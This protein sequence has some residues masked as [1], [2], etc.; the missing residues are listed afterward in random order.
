MKTKEPLNQSVNFIG[1]ARK[2]LF[3][4]ERPKEIPGEGLSAAAAPQRHIRVKVTMNIDGDLLEAFKAQAKDLGRSYQLLINEV[5]REHVEGTKPER[6][7]K[8]IGNILLSDESFLEVLRQ[9]L[10]RSTS[11]AK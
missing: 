8:D 5:L 4:P 2:A 3:G 7:A 1:A 9:A 6:L 10:E 11:V